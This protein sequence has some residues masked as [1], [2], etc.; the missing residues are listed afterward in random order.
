LEDAKK[1]IGATYELVFME[2][3]EKGQALNDYY[4]NQPVTGTWKATKLTGR[5]L[6]RADVSFDQQATI[7]SQ[8]M[9][10]MTFNREG[11]SQFADITKRNINK[12]VAI[13]L[14]NKIVSAPNVQNEIN[15]G[16]AQITGLDSLEEAQRLKNRLNEGILPVPAKLIGQNTV[17]PTLGKESVQKSLIAGLF[18]LILIGIFM[19]SYYKVPGLL[20]VI[21]LSLYTIFSLALFEV[22]PVTLTLAGIAGFILSIGMAVDAN[23]LIF[24]RMKEELRAG[25]PLNKSVEEGFKRA[26]N[27]VRDSNF[28][29]LITCFILWMFTTGFVKGFALTLGVGILVSMFT[30]ITVSRNLLRLFIGTKLEKLIKI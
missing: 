17:G 22:I 11:K 4:T 16:D 2:E 28:S 18:G 7:N 29:S 21:A 25:K 5:Q 13:V 8:P 26:W 27:S 14:D 12:R 19:V 20:A 1:R 9:V 24:E 10:T 30:A 6:I 23:I 3:D 15:S